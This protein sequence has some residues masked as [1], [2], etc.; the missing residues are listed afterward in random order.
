MHMKNKIKTQKITNYLNSVLIYFSR[1][2]SST[3]N[4]VPYFT[5]DKSCD[6][7]VM[8]NRY[9]S[10]ECGE[11]KTIVEKSNACFQSVDKL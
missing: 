10:A 2:S 6:R 7:D 4:Q 9:T 11:K 1:I 5:L 8:H 3:K